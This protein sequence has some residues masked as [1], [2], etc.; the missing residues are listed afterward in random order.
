LTGTADAPEV[1]INPLSVLTPGM[2]R[3]IFRT[4]PPNLKDPGG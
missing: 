4:A 2:F 1:S 3:D